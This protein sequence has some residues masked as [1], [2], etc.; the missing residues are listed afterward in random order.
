MGGDAAT[1]TVI[2]VGN[3]MVGHRFCDRLSAHEGFHGQIT[4]FGE[5]PRPAYDRVHLSDAFAG[6]T[7]DDLTLASREWYTARGITLYTGERVVQI[8]RAEQRVTTDAGRT[9]GYGT[10][11]LATGSAPFV[12]TV[13]GIEAGCAA[14]QRQTA[15]A[16]RAGLPRSAHDRIREVVRQGSGMY[17]SCRRPLSGRGSNFIELLVIAIAEFRKLFTQVRLP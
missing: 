10:L 16:R 8:H 12:P 13:P 6:K 5:E 11:V 4:C 9:F 15:P 17:P 3:G 2:V 14:L 1:S 7:A